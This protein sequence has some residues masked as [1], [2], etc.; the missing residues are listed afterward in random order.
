MHQTFFSLQNNTVYTY[1]Y[2]NTDPYSVDGVHWLTRA[3]SLSNF[4]K[5]EF[6]LNIYYSDGGSIAYDSVHQVYGEFPIIII[7][8]LSTV[9]VIMMICFKS[10][11]APA[12]LVVTII[13]TLAFC[14][15][16]A[17][18]TYQYGVL[19]WFGYYAFGNYGS[20][21]WLPPIMCFTIIV[22][23][24][25]DYDVFLISRVLEYREIG[26]SPDASILKGMY[27]TGYIITDAG[28]IMAVA[29][30]FIINNNIYFH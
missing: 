8:T 17:V 5:T 11:S 16:L 9:F 10:I 19:S 30:N 4:I 1:F 27:K 3:R 13:L 24:A 29:V 20:I 26:Y 28:I 7:A 25:L 15:G 6:N 2:L 14:Y 12:R 22:G 18:L 21:N 23:L